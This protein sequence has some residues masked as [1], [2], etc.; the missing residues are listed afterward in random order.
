MGPPQCVAVLSNIDRELFL[1]AIHLEH[2]PEY[3]DSHP[4]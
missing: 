3:T 2:M 4:Q 1:K